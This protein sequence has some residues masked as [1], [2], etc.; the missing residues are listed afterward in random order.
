MEAKLNRHPFSNE[1]SLDMGG[2]FQLIPLEDGRKRTKNV[3]SYMQFYSIQKKMK[4][5]SWDFYDY[6]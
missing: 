3:L 1:V 5:V 4:N 6:R 2:D